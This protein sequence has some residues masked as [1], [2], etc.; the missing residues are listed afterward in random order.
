M[1]SLG[2]VATSLDLRDGH[3]LEVEVEGQ[4]CFVNLH[5]VSWFLL[6]GYVR[7]IHLFCPGFKSFEDL[8]LDYSV[9][10]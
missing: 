1:S 8:S 2:P 4:L 10:F 3:E 9:D 7:I 6:L 5:V